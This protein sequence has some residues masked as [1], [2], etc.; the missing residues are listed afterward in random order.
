MQENSTYLEENSTEN[1]N[2]N[3]EFEKQEEYEHPLISIIKDKLQPPHIIA[4]LICLFFVGFAVGK[5]NTVSKTIYL[6]AVS[7]MTNI[8]TENETLNEKYSAL[9]NQKKALQSEYDSYKTKM[10][11]YESTQAADAEKEKLAMQKE[12]EAQK[13]IQRTYKDLS[14]QEKM[15]IVK[16]IDNNP[17]KD[18]N[19]LWK[20]V[21]DKYRISE[22]DV[23]IIHNDT[24]IMK[25][26]AEE[27][28]VTN[29]SVEYDAVLTY[30]GKE[31]LVATSKE[32]LD[33]Y[34]SAKTESELN[35]MLLNGSVFHVE[36]GVKVKIVENKGGTVK[37][38]IL[39]GDSNGKTVWTFTEAV[40]KR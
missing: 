1:E 35:S 7:E 28:R 15:E 39:T 40:K 26:I 17:T 14:T 10:Q 4:I 20:E 5:I 25:L 18:V 22:T 2:K 24:E 6:Q 11:P 34:L 12:E 8:Q 21:A 36:D 30:D 27:K 3:T 37:V 38:K 31:I 16:Y 13:S 29:D 19:V 23:T 9:E 33:K 32:N